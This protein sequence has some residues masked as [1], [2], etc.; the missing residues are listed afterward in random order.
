MS[1]YGK[2]LIEQA[3]QKH[4]NLQKIY[5]P[6]KRSR[7]PWSMSEYTK[8]LMHTEGLTEEDAQR[9][10]KLLF[11][12]MQKALLRGDVAII[13]GVGKLYVQYMAPRNSDDHEVIPDAARV[14]F[15]ASTGIKHLIKPNVKYYAR[16]NDHP[17]PRRQEEQVEGNPIDLESFVV[18]QGW[19]DESGSSLEEC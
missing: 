8:V 1:E 2:W 9:V 11:S 12:V 16:F 17:S 3:R 4:N 14:V 15:R 19:E 6:N 18:E 5:K 13:P 7:R 10:L